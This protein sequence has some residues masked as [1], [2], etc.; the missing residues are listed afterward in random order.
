MVK[1][2]NRKEVLDCIVGNR[3]ND[4]DSARHTHTHFS[5]RTLRHQTSKSPGSAR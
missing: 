3:T 4:S 2:Q 1:T 5:E